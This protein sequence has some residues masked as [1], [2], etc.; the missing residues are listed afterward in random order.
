MQAFDENPNITLVASKT[1]NWKIDEAYRITQE[2]FTDY[3]DIGVIFAAND[4]MALG[5]IQFLTETG[6]DQVLVAGFDALSE[7]Q[8]ASV[9]GV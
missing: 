6:R 2:L 1:A 3:P 8:E 4:M 7:A 5:A 9:Q